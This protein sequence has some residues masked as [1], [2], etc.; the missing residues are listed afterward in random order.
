MR[1]MKEKVREIRRKSFVCVACQ[2]DK[3]LRVAPYPRQDK[4]HVH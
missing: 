1:N 4:E 2:K 3:G